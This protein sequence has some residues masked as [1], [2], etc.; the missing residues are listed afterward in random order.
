MLTIYRA[1]AGAGKTHKL[2]GE[3]LKLLFSAPGAYKRILAVTFTN[4]ATEEMKSRI[5]SEL[6][7]LASGAPS[8][9]VEALSQQYQW[10]EEKVRQT[11]RQI[12]IALLHDYSAFNISTIDRFFQQV[13]RAFTREIG[14]Q[15]GYG[16]EMDK[17]LVLNEAIDSLLND[18]AK[19]ENKVLLDWLLR[20]AED[21]IEEGQGWNFRSDILSLAGELFKE[22]YKAFHTEETDD[23]TDKQSLE[24]YK[25]KL[26]GIL[27]QTEKEAKEIGQQALRIMEQQ[28]LQPS[29]FSGGS[30]SPL[31]LFNVW[32]QGELKAPSATFRKLMDQP[33]A[34][35]TKKASAELRQQIAQAV[36]AG[37]NAF[38]KQLIQHYD[39]ATDYFT[40][41]EIIR[42]YY[43][44]GILTDIARQ[45]SAYRAKKNIMLIA[46][47]NELLSRVINGSDASFI[48][49]KTGTQID[50]YMIDEF[51]DTSGMQWSNF[52]PLVGES[53]AQGH[54]NLIVGDVKQ[55]I[56]RFRN[57]DWTLLD[58]QVHHDFIPS[59][60]REETLQANWRSCHHIVAFNNALFTL[61]PALL[62][63]LYNEALA[64]SSLTQ[65]EQALYNRQLVSAY[66]QCYQQIPPRFQQQAGHV[67][68]DFLSGDEENDWKAEAL[69]R[70]PETIRQLQSNGY[71][72]KEIAILVRT[73]H[74]G[75]AV[76]NALLNYKEAHPE[77]PYS[78]DIISDEALFINSSPTVR[79][80]IA[81]FR[82]LRNPGDPSLRKMA[83]YAYR[84]I[85]GALA[86]ASMADENW[87]NQLLTYA[88]YAL[89]ELTEALL[90]MVSTT[91]S[92]SEQ[93]FAQAFLDKVAEFVQKENADLNDFL[94][95]WDKSGY[96][97]TIA[98]P[99]GQNAIRILTVHKSK[100]LGFKAVILPF[101][102]WELDHKGFHPV[103]LWCHPRQKP[104]DQLPLVPVRYGQ[105][106][107]ATH[108][109]ADYFQERL[110]AF[111]DNLN[112]LYVALTRAKEELILCAPRPKKLSK[113]GEPERITSIGDLLWQALRTESAQTQQGEPLESLPS[114]FDA[115][116]G[117]F[118]WGDWWH[119]EIKEQQ[120]EIEEIPMQRIVSISPDERLHLRLHGTS[121]S[122]DDTQRKHGTVM[123]E[124]L[125]RIRTES[126]I[127][128]AVESY[129]MEGVI[130]QAEGAQI[131]QKLTTLLRTPQ[132]N[133]WYNGTYH[134]LNEVEI[135]FEGG[136]TKRPD[137]VMLRGDE[138]VVV[139]YK[140]GQRQLKSH[141]AQVR[142]YLHLIRQMGYSQVNGYL[143]YV[144]LGKIEAVKPQDNF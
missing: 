110:N 49:E 120:S 68:L 39:H 35:T 124:V 22:S 112:T 81:A 76:A 96:K 126:D 137:R 70:L 103:I 139:D 59:L 8:D 10:S 95:W 51:Q 89:Y 113:S 47:T 26:Y 134:V 102:D 136:L 25:E 33:E 9:Y 111:M 71:A 97:Q 54:E 91:I 129:Q 80:F 143:W 60:V 48:Y 38:V 5:V 121:F 67:R 133:N 40:A 69:V 118:E 127:S 141:Q 92:E 21:R 135:L 94:N 30:R 72:L 16:I 115:E 11:A 64:S 36:E 74:E 73:N 53:M 24:K 98:T 27:R 63:A 42:Y 62:Q 117:Y 29:D 43:T 45:I 46:D 108:F 44:L 52:R 57:S 107:G 6:H 116:E 17:D 93:V 85:G 13:T 144:A 86:E 131:A 140:F 99:D 79:F 3:Y 31:L 4:K 1:S 23:A 123:H 28:G 78:Y 100:G 84:L 128:T 88:H 138:V 56:Y 142:N 20:F 55:S 66:A 101:C 15:G 77:D 109:A 14:L 37:L 106:L 114:H 19:P 130:T 61:A 50:H 75:A 132:V 32:A 2:T 90:R 65:E 58:Q 104:F 18:L 82:F 125:S 12:L 41:K 87:I 83:Q 7:H 105:G 119:P 122:F 34:Y